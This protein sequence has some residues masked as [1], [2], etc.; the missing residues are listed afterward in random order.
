MR[1]EDCILLIVDIS[2]YTKFVKHQ[3]TR[4]D[5]QAP[6]DSIPV[7]KAQA[8]FIQQPDLTSNPADLG[9]TG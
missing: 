6:S 3:R 5:G 1:V 2:G 4:E 9:S 8:G 7:P